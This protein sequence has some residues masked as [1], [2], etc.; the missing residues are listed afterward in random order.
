MI[1]KRKG[2]GGEKAGKTIS[3]WKKIDKLISKGRRLLGTQE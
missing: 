1:N 2:E 3:G